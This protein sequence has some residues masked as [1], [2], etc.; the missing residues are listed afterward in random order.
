MQSVCGGEFVFPRN[1][2]AP[3]SSCLLYRFELDHKMSP[4]QGTVAPLSSDRTYPAI[5]RYSYTVS[6][7]V[8]G[9]PL[10][11]HE[12]D[13][14]W[15]KAKRQVHTTRTDGSDVPSDVSSFKHLEEPDVLVVVFA[16]GFIGVLPAWTSTS[17]HAGGFAT[18]ELDRFLAARTILVQVHQRDYPHFDTG[19]CGSRVYIYTVSRVSVCDCLC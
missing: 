1:T 11:D 10:F 7:L 3:P 4:R 15:W 16:N 13:S 18:A 2:F 19:F 5:Q 6:G 12:M 14:A 9:Y 8:P 17:E